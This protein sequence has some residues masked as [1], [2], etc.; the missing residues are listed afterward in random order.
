VATVVHCCKEAIGFGPARH[1]STEAPC[2]RDLWAIWGLSLRRECRLW[3]F[4]VPFRR[5]QPIAASLPLA[6]I[7][8]SHT[9]R[10]PPARDFC[11]ACAPYCT[12]IPTVSRV[13]HRVGSRG[14]LRAGAACDEARPGHGRHI[15]NGLVLNLPSIDKKAMHDVQESPLRQSP[16]GLLGLAF[17]SIISQLFRE[18]TKTISTHRL[19]CA[20]ISHPLPFPT[21][22]EGI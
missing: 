12:A 7:R 10:M 1:Q 3:G 11:T 6:A 22:I 17:M 2:E 9:A 18:V 21:D 8:P 16:G 14:D 19:H 4:T 15:P 20:R 5:L 13:L